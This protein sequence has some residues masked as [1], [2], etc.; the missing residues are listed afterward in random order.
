MRSQVPYLIPR[1]SSFEYCY[2]T[3]WHVQCH[4]SLASTVSR[5]MLVLW[6]RIPPRQTTGLMVFAPHQPT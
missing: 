2:K 4:L 6:K 1:L 5:A 3:N